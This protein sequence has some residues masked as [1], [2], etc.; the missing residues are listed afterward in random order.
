VAARLRILGIVM[1]IS[2]MI[3][4][5]VAGYTLL[6]TTQGIDSL[7]AFSSAQGV[8]LSYNENGQL[9]DRGSP[10]AADKIMALVTQDWGYTIAAG[11]MNPNDPLVNTASEYMFQMGVISYHTL[12]GETTVTLAEDVEYKGETFK[13]GEHVFVNDGRYWAD[14]D[15][16][17]PIEGPARAQLWTGTAHALIGQLGVGAVTA[18]TLTIGLGLVGVIGGL[19]GTLLLLGVGLVWVS[20]AKLAPAT[21]SARVKG[22]GAPVP[23]A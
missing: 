4:M 16:M 21:A 15:R 2:G 18:S 12:Y 7:Q 22:V 6:R 10:E 3:G 20:A 13:A 8:E 11:E 14:F 17:H 1:I 9:V 5:G 19:A 23:N